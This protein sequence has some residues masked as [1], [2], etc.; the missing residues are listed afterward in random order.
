VT[1]TTVRD[2]ND[3]AIPSESGLDYRGTAPSGW[4]QR[5]MAEV[6]PSLFRGL[7]N[8]RYSV[9]LLRNH[10]YDYRRNRRY[11]SAVERGDTERKLA[12]LITMSYHGIEKGL[13]LREPRTGFGAQAIELLLRR[14]D[15]Y[16]EHAGP[17]P[18]VWAALN[19]LDEYWAFNVDR[20]HMDQPLRG[21]LDELHERADRQANHGRGGT[22]RV[23][24]QE[25]HE[26]AR[27][28]LSAFFA[29][30]SSVRTF[31][32]EP[33][34]PALVRDAVRMAQKTPSVCNR[35]S[36]RVWM[37]TSP[38]LREEALGVQG[39]AR[40]FS[41]QV[42]K[43]LVVTSDLTHFQAAGERNQAWVDG[44]MFA[45][46]LVYALH[47]LGLGT[48]CLNWSKKLEVDHE[49]RRHV[50]IPEQEVVI[51]LIA[52]GHLPEEFGV[53]QSPLKS[54]DEVLRVLP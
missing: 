40:G 19:A 12:A 6:P 30:R 31:S 8:A 39:G 49:L 50:P 41:E 22:K 24:R 1:P 33:V 7:R 26:V 32:S 46:S 52:V 14:L 18:V 3:R 20:G 35:Q 54:V 43:V 25:I 47:S 13:A 17:G 37:L 38:A 29:S 10:L 4:R 45:M 53:P 23:T 36:T 34:D 21:R 9:T 44:G 16:L 48:C 42:D 15:R 11:T 27:M 5:L 28:D 51:M 2:G